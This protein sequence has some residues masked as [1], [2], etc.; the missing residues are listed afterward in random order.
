MRYLLALGLSAAAML[1]APSPAHA[2]CEDPSEAEPLAT[3]QLAAQSLQPP[4]VST[5]LGRITIAAGNVLLVRHASDLSAAG[6]SVTVA[7]AVVGTPNAVTLGDGLSNDAVFVASDGLAHLT[8]FD[9][10]HAVAVWRVELTRE[11]CGDDSL[12][13]TPAV[14]LRRLGTDAFRAQH[15]HDIVYV[16]TKLGCGTETANRVYAIN[17]HDGGIVWVFNSTEFVDMDAALADPFLDVENDVLYVATD[18]T[19]TTQDSLFAINAITGALIWSANHD[20]IWTPPVRRG[21]R[22]YVATL[23]GELKAIDA[24]T[25]EEIWT[26][27]HPD[28]VPMTTGLFVEFRAPYEGLIATVDYTGRVWMVRDEGESAR[29]EWIAR[30][31]EAEATSRV[32]M[33]PASGMLYVG[34]DD[35]R[36]YQMSVDDGTTVAS[37]QVGDDDTATVGVPTLF[38]E[39]RIGNTFDTLRLVVGASGGTIAKFCL[40]WAPGSH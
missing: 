23:F 21:D 38:F 27:Q 12:A 9:P 24:A 35:G 20:R 1:L 28:P 32:A 18:R 40:P 39:D 36:V 11:S 8:R 6:G 26:H 33:H 22:I 17:A 13:G 19:T 10:E 31:G 29:D 7:G 2:S 5:R 4:G 34:A 14:Y 16:A 3:T 25:G 30:P 37:R 15:D